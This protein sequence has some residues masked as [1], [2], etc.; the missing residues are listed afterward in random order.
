M[1]VT[2]A[3]PPPPAAAHRLRSALLWAGATIL[4]VTVAE[5]LLGEPYGVG[6]GV[7]RPGP[8]A[9]VG[10]DLLA[11]VLLRRFPV[12]VF[13]MLL[14]AGLG[15]ALTEE[16]LP[17]NLRIGHLLPAA[18]ALCYLV[19]VRSGTVALRALGV[20]VAVMAGYQVVQA[21]RG[22]DVQLGQVQY[23]AALMMLFAWSIGLSVRQA[24]EAASAARTQATEQ[25]ITAERMRIAREL[26]DMVAHSIGI[27]AIQAGVGSRV[28]GSQPDEARKAL[29]AIEETSRETLAG[30]RRTLVAL[31]QADP[32]GA[33]P[34]PSEPMAGL[35][36]VERLAAATATAGVRVEVCRSGE[37]RPLPADIELSA[38]RIV[39]EAVTNVVRHAGTGHCRVSVGYGD[40][41]LSV[42]VVDEGRGVTGPAPGRGFGLVGMRE[43]VALLHGRFE[44]GPRPGGGFRVAAVLPLPAPASAVVTAR[45]LPDA[46]EVR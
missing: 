36:D 23:P 39:Q 35:A 9:A 42:E 3:A 17:L 38:F 31:R 32:Q 24:R 43:R 4:I 27:I 28:I 18:A 19:T 5:S 41:E 6:H 40:E 14:S 29:Q 2:P 1:D 34:V 21:E 20:S 13:G 46:A 8:L 15:M 33:G 7:Q 44:A 11:A 10:F 12:A 16:L 45:P 37:R 22:V 30:L 25:A 26:H